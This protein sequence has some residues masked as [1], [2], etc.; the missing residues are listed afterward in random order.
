ML[1]PSTRVRPLSMQLLGSEVILVLHIAAF[2]NAL[3]EIVPLSL[4]R[5]STATL[6]LRRVRLDGQFTTGLGEFR[7]YRGCRTRSFSQR[8]GSR[9]RE[10]NDRSKSPNWFHG[11][12]ALKQ[13]P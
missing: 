2:G 12:A 13:P 3:F 4:S 1:T 6:P 10:S 9:K 11:S 8:G 5:A 7:A